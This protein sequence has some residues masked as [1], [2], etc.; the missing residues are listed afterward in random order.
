MYLKEVKKDLTNEETAIIFQIL[1]EKSING[2]IP[3][4]SL[5]PLAS[6]YGVHKATIWRISKRGRNSIDSGT[7]LEL[8]CTTEPVNVERQNRIMMK[9]KPPSPQY[10]YINAKH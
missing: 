4:G 9:F 3:Y 1:L 6:K 2:K 5:S 10:R 7:G 8:F